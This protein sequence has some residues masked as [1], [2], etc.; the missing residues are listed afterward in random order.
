MDPLWVDRLAVLPVAR[1]VTR[2]RNELPTIIEDR[3]PGDGLKGAWFHGDIRDGTK[4]PEPTREQRIQSIATAIRVL[5]EDDAAVREIA[6]ML[7][8]P[9]RPTQEPT[10]LIGY[11]RKRGHPMTPENTY[12]GRGK[13]ECRACRRERDQERKAAQ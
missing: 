2:R 11:C 5:G 6:A 8:Q 12:T 10:T 1:P 7:H 4:I 9:P 3:N 13:H